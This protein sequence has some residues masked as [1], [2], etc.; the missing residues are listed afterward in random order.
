MNVKV[1]RRLSLI[2]S[3]AKTFLS[4]LFSRRIRIPLLLMSSNSTCLGNEPVPCSGHGNCVNQQC[5]CYP[6][7][8]NPNCSISQVNTIP[9]MFDFFWIHVYCFAALFA[10]VS[11]LAVV[12]LSFVVRERGCKN[13]HIA[14]FSLFGLLMLVGLVRVL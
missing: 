2:F 12:Q 11:V 8:Q 3:D 7:F 5:V 1:N 4:S 13:V 9:G 6:L 10:C 14:T